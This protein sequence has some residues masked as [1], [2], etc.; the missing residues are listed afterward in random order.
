MPELMPPYVLQCECCKSFA[1]LKLEDYNRYVRLQSANDVFKSGKLP[2]M[3]IMLPSSICR[4]SG[5][6]NG[7][8]DRRQPWTVAHH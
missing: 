8:H 5:C 7:S 4:R 2:W 3:A 6:T 1:A